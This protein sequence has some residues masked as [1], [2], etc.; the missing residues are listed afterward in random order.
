MIDRDQLTELIRSALPGAMVEA[1]D[2]TGTHD[3]YDVRVTWQGFAG[4]PLI[5]QHRKV[6]AAVDG[7]LK[8]GRLHALQIKTE[9]PVAASAH[10]GIRS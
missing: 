2:W 5:D 8:D 6:Y 9:T 1:S 10:R 3:H 4:M 7:A